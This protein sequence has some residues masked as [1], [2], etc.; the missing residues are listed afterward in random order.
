[1]GHY[2]IAF[3][4]FLLSSLSYGNPQSFCTEAQLEAIGH[5]QESFDG[6][7]EIE[8]VANQASFRR[9]KPS[10]EGS[11]IQGYAYKP[12]AKERTSEFEEV[13][14]KM[15]SAEAAKK[16]WGTPPLSVA[17]CTDIQQKAIP[18][19]KGYTLAAM[20]NISRTGGGWLSSSV[21]AQQLD[22]G[23]IGI[24]T[25]SLITSTLIPKIP[26]S[27]GDGAFPFYRDA[28]HKE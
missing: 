8:V 7:V 11:T 16:I 9:A 25:P 12:N 1:M 22:E 15:K 23:S 27:E 19:D 28:D 21:I 14:C 18:Q 17:E 5:S 4:S 10:I 2:F 6:T 20:K 26:N 24:Y 13:W 3:A